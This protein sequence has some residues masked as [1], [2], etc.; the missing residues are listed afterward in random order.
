MYYYMDW[1]VENKE[2]IEVIASIITALSF[3]AIVITFI[4]L[5]RS[6]KALNFEIIASC[7]E[8]FAKILYRFHSDPEKE[9]IVLRQYIDLC[10]EQL[11]YYRE[12]YI[13][14]SSIVSE[15]IDGMIDFLP[16]YIGGECI[17]LENSN[18][19]K[20][21]HSKELLV[22]YS[23]L[24]SYFTIDSDSKVYNLIKQ[25]EDL[26]DQIVRQELIK[27]VRKKCRKGW[28]ARLIRRFK[29]K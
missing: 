6:I 3:L 10:H 29:K 12:G 1:L 7:S 25:R 11:F 16:V 19:I 5:R 22:N 24:K 17:N 28:F 20:N 21:I 14:G 15:W 13:V 27:Y 2:L 8:R 23:N 9:V 26:R 4:S 18:R